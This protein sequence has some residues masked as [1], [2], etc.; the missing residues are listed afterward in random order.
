MK[1]CFF[2]LLLFNLEKLKEE[3]GHLLI[4]LVYHM[5]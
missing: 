5:L 4:F 3:I 2:L 1:A